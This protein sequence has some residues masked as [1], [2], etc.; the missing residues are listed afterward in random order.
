MK[1]SFWNCILYLLNIIIF[2]LLVWWWVWQ[3]FH[4]PSQQAMESWVM[5]RF[6]NK[7]GA[8]NHHVPSSAL[9]EIW[10]DCMRSRSHPLCAACVQFS[11]HGQNI[12]DR[13][14]ILSKRQHEICI[15]SLAST[16][17]SC[18]PIAGCEHGNFPHPVLLCI[19][20]LDPLW[21]VPERYPPPC[22]DCSGFSATPH[23]PTPPHQN[24]DNCHKH[25]KPTGWGNCY[26]VTGMWAWGGLASISWE[27]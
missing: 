6:L 5:P 27:Q 1:L 15:F 16:H 2:C 17:F 20:T 19:Q 21:N 25:R 11:S 12:T 14:Q 23:H 24:T 22:F 7:S 13:K 8:L 4:S 18:Q 10:S 26:W 9:G 3:I